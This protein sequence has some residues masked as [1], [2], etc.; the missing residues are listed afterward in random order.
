VARHRSESRA[1]EL[2]VGSFGPVVLGGHDRS[3]GGLE[4]GRLAATVCTF[5]LVFAFFTGATLGALAYAGFLSIEQLEVPG[6]EVD[7]TEVPVVEDADPADGDEPEV[8][9]VTGRQNILLVGSD[10]REGLTDQ[11]LL[12]LGTEDEGTNLTDTVILMQLDADAGRASMLS[13]PRDLLVTRCD[14][15][16]GRI[17]SAFEHG[18]ESAV[19]GPGCL[20]QTVTNLT[21]IPVHHYV[22]I[23][24]RGFLGAVDAVGGVTFYLDEPLRDVAAGLDVPAGCV[25]FDGTRALG[26]VRARKSLDSDFGRIARQQRFLRELVDEAASLQ[27]LANPARLLAL[28]RTLSGSISTDDQLS[29]SEMVSLAYT[30]RGL[31]NSGLDTR[32]V[33][34]TPTIWNGADVVELDEPAARALFN[35]FREGRLISGERVLADSDAQLRPERVA[36]VRVLNG[37]GTRGL[38]SEAA[39]ALEQRGFRVDDT[40]DAEEIGLETTQVLY[41]PQDREQAEVLAEFLPGSVLLPQGPDVDLTVVLAGDIDLDDLPPPPPPPPAPVPLEP[42]PSE[43]DPGVEGD[44]GLPTPAPSPSSGPGPVEEPEYAGAQRSDVRC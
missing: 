38:A 19:G 36:P 1:E 39:R 15:T 20:V 44:L 18:E 26:F 8:T 7:G 21:G 43:A 24:F 4:W 17:N 13:F 2:K 30:F 40:G 28:V 27:T 3:R 5:L 42:V 23:D 11:Q 33:P 14:G 6:L 35:D 16:R 9:E 10:S 34:G 32:V 29:S 37:V 31:S 12:A 22:Q 41:A 25:T